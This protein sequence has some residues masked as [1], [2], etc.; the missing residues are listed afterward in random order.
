MNANDWPWHMRVTH[1]DGTVREEDYHAQ[2]Y[3]ADFDTIGFARH[4]SSRPNVARVDLA[5]SFVAGEQ[6]TP[7]TTE[8]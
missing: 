5:T 8:V 1:T 3:A 7:T 2:D 6:V 4:L